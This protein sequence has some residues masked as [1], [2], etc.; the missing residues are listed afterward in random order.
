MRKTGLL[1]IVTALMLVIG[2]GV[3]RAA[4]GAL[5]HA[6]SGDGRATTVIGD[7]VTDGW[8]LAVQDDGKVVVVGAVRMSASDWDWGLARY[9]ANGTLDTAFGIGNDGRVRTGWTGGDD[10]AYAVK[11]LPS[12]KI[13]VAGQAG[14]DIAIARYTPTGHLDS[15]FGGGDGKVVTNVTPGFDEVWDIELLAGGKILIGGDAGDDFLVATYGPKGGLITSFGGGDGF[16]TIH[17]NNGTLEGRELAVQSNGKILLT[18]YIYGGGSAM[19]LARFKSNGQP[20]TTFGGSHEGLTIAL[21][22][23]DSQ[24]WGIKPL[25]GGKVLVVGSGQSGN[26]EDSP[27]DAATVRFDQ[28]G[29]QDPDFGDDGVV[30]A[31]LGDDVDYVLSMAVLARGKML[32]AGATGTIGHPFHAVV[33]KLKPNGTLDHTFSGDGVADGGFG[34]TGAEFWGVATAPSNKVVAAGYVGFAS[35][36]DAFATARFVG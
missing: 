31:D 16:G 11:I 32:I 4:S 10:E 30:F 1:A 18:G 6:F 14:Q 3:A 24:G 35:A 23:R 27:S 9:K 8:D 13:L 20:D 2:A 33:A 25:A 22:S 34:G 7:K 17:S 26:Q 5:D 15:T 12:G 29:T 36:P 28:D 21:E 19:A